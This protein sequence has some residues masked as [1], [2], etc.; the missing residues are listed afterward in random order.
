MAPLLTTL[1]F[2]G[3]FFFPPFH[4][5]SSFSSCPLAC[6]TRRCL[7]CWRATRPRATSC[8]LERTLG[9]LCCTIFQWLQVMRQGYAEGDVI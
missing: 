4:L 9:A 1:L 5:S 3:V 7:R 8:R 6:L 2:I